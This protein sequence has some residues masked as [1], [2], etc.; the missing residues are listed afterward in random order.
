MVVLSGVADRKVA[1]VPDLGKL[2]RPP[3]PRNLRKTCTTAERGLHSR[4]V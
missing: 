4:P 3:A 2:E 1:W